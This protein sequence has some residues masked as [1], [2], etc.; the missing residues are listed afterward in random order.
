ME[1]AKP[2]NLQQFFQL[3]DIRNSFDV[4]SLY[5]QFSPA[6]SHI[7]TDFVFLSFEYCSDVIITALFAFQFIV[8]FLMDLSYYLLLFPVFL[9]NCL[10]RHGKHTDN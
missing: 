8:L 5:A 9:S 6:H 3:L 1:L 2:L 10:S 4:L 7:F